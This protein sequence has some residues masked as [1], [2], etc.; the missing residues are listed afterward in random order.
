[1]INQLD[2]NI[3]IKSLFFSLLIFIILDFSWLGIIAKGFY[4]QQIN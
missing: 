3:F 4:H 2:L 1:M